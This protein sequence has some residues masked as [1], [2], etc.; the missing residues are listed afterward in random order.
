MPHGEIN[1][2]GQQ[3]L[4]RTENY[5]DSHLGLNALLRSN[6]I[7]NV[8]HKLSGESIVLFKEKINYKLA[9]SGGCKAHIDATAYTYVKEI[10]HISVLLAVV[11]TNIGNRGLEV[12]RGSHKMDV[13]IGE[14]NCIELAWNAKQEWM[15]VELEAGQALLFGSYLAHRSA[16]NTSDQDR[17]A[18]YATYNLSSEGDLHN[19]Y[20]AR[21]RV[22]WPPTHM[23]KPGDKLDVGSLRYAFGSP[24]MSINAGSQID[25]IAPSGKKRSHQTAQDLI[26]MLNTCGE[27]D[28]IGERISQLAH[29][30]Q[31]AYLASQASCDEE[32]IIA[33]LLH[34]IGHFLP[35]AEMKFI[36]HEVR[37][38]DENVGRVG[39]ERIGDAYVMRLGFSKKVGFL[40][41]SHVAAKRY[42]CA[43]EDDYYEGLSDASKKSLE[44]QGGPFEGAEL[45]KWASH[46][47]CDD[48]CL[49]RRFDDGAK[50]VGLEVPSPEAYKQMMVRN[51]EE[52]QAC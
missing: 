15:P 36:A 4:C 16:A 3:V 30:L 34:D 42:L 46:P 39:H 41:G 7:L 33:A 37:S 14:D 12:V 48:M 27:G 19:K 1:A 52:V 6:T 8:L 43:V 22:E 44:F 26:T 24:M 13:P 40:V 20:Y 29:S 11:A 17:K 28:Y 25:F 10:K 5:G 38:M 18:L 23:R 50:V 49:L 2:R 51:L 47:Y 35:P 9:C 45:G 21:R 31:A 32:T